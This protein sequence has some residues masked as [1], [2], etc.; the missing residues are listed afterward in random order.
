[1]QP[2]NTLK[3]LT[4]FDVTNLLVGAIVGADIY[5]VA[6]LGSQYLGPASLVAWIA[7]GLIAIIIALNFAEC[8][9]LVPKVGGAYAYAREVWG[10][11]AGFIV[12]WA[13]W[14]AEVA[15]LAVFPVA[16]VRYLSFFFPS[17]TV[18]EGAIIKLLFIASITY[19]N[20]RG[21]KLAGRA[22][23]VLTIAKLSPLLLLIVAGLIYMAFNPTQTIANFVPFAPLGFSN[24]VQ[25]LVL[26][27]WAYAG[28]ELAVIPSNEVEN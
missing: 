8:A 24:F 3:K 20:I 10:D 4:F 21:S 13:L 1:M 15:A 23:D 22:N 17:I 12:G 25:A 2:N 16:F 9:T 14:L 11:F 18:T 7:A 28:F 19:V 27:F 6:S 26:I 5:V